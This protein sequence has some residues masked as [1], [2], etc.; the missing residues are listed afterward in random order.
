MLLDVHLDRTPLPGLEVQYGRGFAAHAAAIKQQYVAQRSLQ[1][2]KVLITGPPCSGKSALA[3]H[4]ASCYSLPLLTLHEICAAAHA[5][6]PAL[7][8]ADASA[9]SSAQSS[10]GAAALPPALL[11]RLCR[12]VMITVRVRNRGYV[13]DG[14]PAT[15]REAREL[16]T[17]A[18]AWS[19]AELA[20]QSELAAMRVVAEA[21]TTGGGKGA[22]AVVAKK[23]AKDAKPTSTR[24]ESGM[25]DVVEPR[26][27]LDDLMPN[28]VVRFVCTCHTMCTH[29]AE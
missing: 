1:P 11:A 20:E 22:K 6:S 12:A 10:T 29:C 24:A 25:D 8:P 9:V 27:L 26:D 16:F 19:E 7:S 23:P 18:R 2:M 5:L 17:D 21:D 15:L 14:C 4:L 3:R 13:L 28:A